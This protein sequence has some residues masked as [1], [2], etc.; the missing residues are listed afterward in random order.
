VRLRGVSAAIGTGLRRLWDDVLAKVAAGL[1]L[2]EELARVT[3]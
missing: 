2:V 1:T 3:T